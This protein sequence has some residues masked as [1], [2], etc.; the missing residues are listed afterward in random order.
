MNLKISAILADYDGTLAPINVSR[1]KSKPS[2]E[3]LEAL[4]QL[5]EKVILGVISMKDYW[6]LKN[7]IPFAHIYGCIGGLE[8]ITR[9][10][11]FIRKPAANKLENIKKFYDYIAEHVN[12]F[13]EKSCIEIEVKRLINR[14]IAG[15]SLDWRNCQET[16]SIIQHLKSIAKHFNL[17]A[18]DSNEPFI[19]IVPIEPDKGAAVKFIKQLFRIKGPILYLGDSMLD[20][21]AFKAA[22]ISIGVIS[23]NDPK[24]LEAQFFINFRDVTKLLKHLIKTDMI[25]TDELPLLKRR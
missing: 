15:L 4:K 9:E 3:L 23:H 7:R 1:E 18:M 21:P 25:F 16:P 12:E 8:I 19:D 13:H 17:H 6:F 5:S 11:A 14:K 20:N 24:L 10:K 22:D 2:R